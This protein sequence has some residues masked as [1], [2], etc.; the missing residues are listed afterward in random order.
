MVNYNHM[1][2][3][4]AH[5]IRQVGS[6]GCGKLQS[7]VLKYSTSYTT[8]RECWCGKVQS[9]GLKYNTSYTQVGSVGVVKYNHINIIHHIPQVG[10]VGVVKYNHMASNIKHHIPQLVW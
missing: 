10:S 6:A 9:H 5:H 8:G 2:S 4:I 3:D 7:H 1:A